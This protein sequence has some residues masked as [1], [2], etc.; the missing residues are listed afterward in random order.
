MKKVYYE[1]IGK[2]YKPVREYDS[3]FQ[4]SWPKGAHLIMCYPGGLSCRYNIDTAYAPMIAA[5]RV[6]ENAISNA[7]MRASDIRPSKTPITEEQRNAWNALSASFGE[8][9]HA[10]SWPSA[11]EACEEAVKAMTDEANK[12][13]QHEAVRK[14]YEQFQ[15]VCKL[16]KEANIDH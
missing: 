11:R 12:L 5:G 4:D 3:N 2:R 8:E 9:N 16:T 14:A 6:A 1:K 13:M 7:L 15:L 10:L